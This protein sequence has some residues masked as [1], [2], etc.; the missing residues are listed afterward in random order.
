MWLLLKVYSTRYS[1]KCQNHN[2]FVKNRCRA[3]QLSTS[4]I[5]VGFSLKYDIQQ[6]KSKREIT[7]FQID[8]LRR[9]VCDFLVLMCTLITEKSPLLSLVACCLKCFSLSFLVEFPEKCEYPSD[10]LLMKLVTYK[11]LTAS[12]ADLA[13]GEFSKFC[14][15]VVFENKE[16]FLSFD[17]DKDRLDYFLWKLTDLK[18]YAK[19]QHV[20]KIVLISNKS[21]IDDNM[22]TDAIVALRSAHDCHKFH[23][24]LKW[25]KMHWQAAG[26]Q[27]RNILTINNQKSY[28]LRENGES[29]SKKQSQW[30]Y[31]NSQYWNLADVICD[32]ASKEEFWWNWISC[33]EKDSLWLV[34]WYWVIFNSF[35]D[36]KPFNFILK[37]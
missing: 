31:W 25:Q 27:E 16:E 28:L 23:V 18:M 2:V 30:G 10:T 9:E 13:K 33:W 15:T 21:L 6:L 19:L 37:F 20:I 5:D 26:R 1:C 24:K 4:K 11:E 35:S 3:N 14:E 29:G 12:V 17:K 22:S 8:K 34:P 7:N 36:I 32:W